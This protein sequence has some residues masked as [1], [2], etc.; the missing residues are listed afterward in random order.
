MSLNFALGDIGNMRSG[1]ERMNMSLEIS[2]RQYN[3][4]FNGTVLPLLSL[5]DAAVDELGFYEI[6]QRIKNTPVK[7]QYRRLAIQLLEE[8]LREH[9]A[10]RPRA[11]DLFEAKQAYE[12]RE[13]QET[14]HTW[15]EALWRLVSHQ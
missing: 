14:S 5:T 2:R 9:Q 3:D 13:W 6:A 4:F 7:E 1:L 15:E 8:N 11:I 12:L 10:E